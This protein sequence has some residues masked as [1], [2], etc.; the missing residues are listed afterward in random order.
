[1]QNATNKLGVEIRTISAD[2]REAKELK[3]CMLKASTPDLT[4]PT[5]V[6]LTARLYGVAPRK[7]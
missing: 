5:D 7:E 1:M 6:G 3:L 2:W 4:L